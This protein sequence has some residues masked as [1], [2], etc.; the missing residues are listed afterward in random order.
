MCQGM[1]CPFEGYEGECNLTTKETRA[2]LNR[3]NREPCPDFST[4]LEEQ[5]YWGWIEQ[6]EAFLDELRTQEEKEI[7]ELLDNAMKGK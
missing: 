4:E 6:V 5:E 7:N 3:F 2:V 1:Q